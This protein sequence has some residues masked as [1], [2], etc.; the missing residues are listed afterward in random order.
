M[1]N[2]VIHKLFLII[3]ENSISFSVFKLSVNKLMKNI[4]FEVQI[5]LKIMAG[6][7]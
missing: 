4:Y 6:I 1:N 5:F 3:I 2:K 7:I